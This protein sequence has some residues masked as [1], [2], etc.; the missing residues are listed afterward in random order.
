MINVV[1]KK[2]M[3]Q[4]VWDFL[5]M[6]GHDK[7]MIVWCQWGTY[8]AEEVR[9]VVWTYAR[10]T[11][12]IK[13]TSN[14][15]ES[16][17]IGLFIKESL[18]KKKEK[19]RLICVTVMPFDNPDEFMSDYSE[20]FEC[21]RYQV[22]A[23]EWI[24]FHP[25]EIH[26]P[27]VDFIQKYPQ[28]L[29][30][31][32]DKKPAPNTVGPSPAIWLDISKMWADSNR[33]F[34]ASNYKMGAIKMVRIMMIGA[35]SSMGVCEPLFTKLRYFLLRNRSY[36]NLYLPVIPFYDSCNGGR[37][38]SDESEEKTSNFSNVFDENG[39]LTW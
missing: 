34:V 38:I 25:S 24:S 5:L 13:T 28:F 35:A 1:N 36:R 8:A 19:E 4:A 3:R 9:D 22:D 15:D 39:N 31:P 18:A 10:S 30:Q 21:I 23:Q 17:D 2:G 29:I 16:I 7:P 11:D 33:G 14:E 6:P 37:E 27:I 20:E 32:Y 26:E 12:R